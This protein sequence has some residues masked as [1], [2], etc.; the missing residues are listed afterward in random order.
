MAGYTRQASSNIA[1]GQPISAQDFNDEFNAIQT[2]FGK[3]GGHSHDPS[4][5]DGGA[6]IEKVGPASEVEVTS[7]GIL[8]KSSDAYTIGSTSLKFHIIKK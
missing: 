7:V 1:D 2:A 5:S 4:D 3:I 8:P 6:P